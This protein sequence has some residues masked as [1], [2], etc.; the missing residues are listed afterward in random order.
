MPFRETC[1]VEER[2]ALMQAYDA[3]A[4]ETDVQVGGSEQLFNLMAGRVLQREHGQRGTGRAAS[5][6]SHGR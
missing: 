6:M 3:V 2:I 1:P 5:T 4:L